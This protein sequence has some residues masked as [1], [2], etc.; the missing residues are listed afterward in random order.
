M[1]LDLLGHLDLL[2]EGDQELQGYLGPTGCQAESAPRVQQV[3]RVL[4]DFPDLL[5]Q[6]DLQVFLGLSMILAVTFC[7]L[8]SAPLVPLVLLECQDSRVIRGTKETR[9]SLA[10]MERR[11]MLVHLAH[12]VFQ[13]LWACR[14]HVVSEVSKVQWEL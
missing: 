5:A 7:V 6:M 14:A 10:K 9:E 13:G 8:Q 2:A 11:V 4:Q 1:N 12:Q 3:L